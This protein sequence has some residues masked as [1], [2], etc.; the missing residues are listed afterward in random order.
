MRLV[1]GEVDG[2]C[3]VADIRNTLLRKKES[4]KACHEK[5]SKLSTPTTG[6]VTLGWSIDEN[7]RVTKPNVILNSTNQEDL[8]LCLQKKLTP[9]RFTRPDSGICN[10][11]WSVTF[12][13]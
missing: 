9:L 7:G 2:F 6:T 11:K 5:A 1:D 4:F 8:A 10:V 3:E 13:D 12:T